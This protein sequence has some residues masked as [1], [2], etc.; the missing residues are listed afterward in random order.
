MSGL[1]PGRK[2]V[3]DGTD[4]N[5]NDKTAN[6]SNK[7]QRTLH[8]A[9]PFSFHDRST[10]SGC[11]K[12][13]LRQ[14]ADVRTHLQRVHMQDLFCPTC[15]HTFI[16]DN[17]RRNF[18]DHVTE[19][20]CQ[21]N[22]QPD[23][24]GITQEFWDLHFK[25]KSQAANCLYDKSPLERKWYYIWDTLFPDSTRPASIYQR[26]A[27]DDEIVRDAVDTYIRSARLKEDLL[28]QLNLYSHESFDA[29]SAIEPHA[30]VL[31]EIVKSVL[32]RLPSFYAQNQDNNSS[33]TQTPSTP[34]PPTPAPQTPM[35]A[36]TYRAV[37]TPI[38]NAPQTALTYRSNSNWSS[39]PRPQPL[40]MNTEPLRINQEPPLISPPQATD[41]HSATHNNI[42]TG[43]S[44]ISPPMHQATHRPNAYH[45]SNNLGIEPP[46]ISPLQSTHRQNAH[47]S[48]N[49][50]FP[51]DGSTG[52][53][54]PKI[55]MFPYH[56]HSG[57][58][59][60][61]SLPVVTAAVA[62]AA[63]ETNMN[64]IHQSDGSRGQL[65]ETPPKAGFAG[66]QIIENELHCGD[67]VNWMEYDNLNLIMSDPGGDDE[68]QQGYSRG[69]GLTYPNPP[70]FPSRMR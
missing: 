64:M 37:T 31:E 3:F 17:K 26:G 2:R 13:S 35:S 49:T 44:L 59:D 5:A 42:S 15:K 25:G 36:V 56:H 53:I 40:G 47:H 39:L 34:I 57:H 67:Q 6:I 11:R 19:K 12:Y 54:D 23:P 30:S 7:R 66:L 58:L 27:E 45:S 28:E 1:V 41:H 9:C 68:L 18:D 24:P 4:G 14:I 65:L 46:L 60:T 69:G 63:T 38:L 50:A 51:S 20:K 52:C 8:V 10:Y 55:T 70:N 43:S 29:F 21:P 48:V 32:Q 22:S 16:G 61:E 62:A 33:L